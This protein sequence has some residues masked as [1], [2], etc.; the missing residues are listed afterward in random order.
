M[1]F[2]VGD[3]QVIG[4]SKPLFSYLFLGINVLVFLFQF[5]L[6]PETLNA[7]IYTYGSLPSEISQGVDLYTL[8]TCMFLHGG[9]MHLIGNM[10][11]LWVFG[12]NIEATIG[13]AA[14]LFFYLAGGIAASAAHILIDPTSSIPTVGASG[15]ISAI[16]GG[17]LIMFPRSRVK[18]LVVYFFRTFTLPAIF[19]LGFWIAQQLI[20]GFMSLGSDGA[21]VAWWAHIG[22]FFFGVAAGLFFRFRY[23]DVELTNRHEAVYYA[24]ERRRGPF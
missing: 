3:D 9:W 15:A 12:D 1:I 13:N 24:E 23:P 5:S 4:G 10:M 20:S 8:I 18:M 22:G 19:F 16:L 11:F 21:G 2:P 17:Y 6:D 7:F 14:F